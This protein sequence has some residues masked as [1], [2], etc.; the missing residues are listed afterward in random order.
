MVRDTSSGYVTGSDVM[1]SFCSCCSTELKWEIGTWGQ[2]TCH[3][4][5]FGE[6]RKHKGKNHIDN[7]IDNSILISDKNGGKNK[8]F[9]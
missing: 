5:R 3:S 8:L 7:H 4:G 2:M 9:C 6:L 1:M